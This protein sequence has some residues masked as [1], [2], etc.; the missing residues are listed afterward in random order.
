MTAMLL[1][2]DS[3]RNTSLKMSVIR[4]LYGLQ[5]ILTPAGYVMIVPYDSVHEP[6]SK[7]KQMLNGQRSSHSQCRAKMTSSPRAAGRIKQRLGCKGRA[8][9]GV[10]SQ[11]FHC[12]MCQVSVNSETQ[13]KQVLTSIQLVL[14]ILPQSSTA[15]HTALICQGCPCLLSHFSSPSTPST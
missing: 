13:L 6:G 15:A 4:D 5:T 2:L 8:V 1:P 9:V 12:E 7:H 14:L 11:P 10:S 3:R